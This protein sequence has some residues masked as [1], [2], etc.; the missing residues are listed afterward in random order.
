VQRCRTAIGAKVDLLLDLPGGQPWAIEIRRSKAPV[1]SKGFHSAS[2]TQAPRG[3]A[4]C[5]PATMP[6]CWAGVMA[7]SLLDLMRELAAPAA[8]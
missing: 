7:L 5:T 2:R 3:P 8:R 6:I 1:P 4:S